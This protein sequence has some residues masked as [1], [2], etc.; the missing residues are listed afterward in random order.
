MAVLEDGSAHLLWMC[1]RGEDL[2]VMA[3][4]VCCNLG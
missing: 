1:H 2:Q 4:V 3:G